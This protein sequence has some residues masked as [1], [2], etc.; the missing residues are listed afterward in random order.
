[1]IVTAD[2]VNGLW[3]YR[4]LKMSEAQLNAISVAEEDCARKK[5]LQ[6]KICLWHERLGHVNF[7]YLSR[8]YKRIGIK[9]KLK[10]R[11][12]CESCLLG[13]AHSKPFGRSKIKTER[14]L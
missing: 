4:K 13:K 5:E 10:D 6:E 2:R 12:K 8:L 9:G 7:G 11:L 1:M 14:V 3:K